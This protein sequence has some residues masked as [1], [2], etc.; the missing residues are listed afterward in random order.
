MKENAEQKADALGFAVERKAGRGG[1]YLLKNRDGEIVLGEGY[2]AGLKEINRFVDIHIKQKAAAV[3]VRLTTKKII[4]SF[5]ELSSGEARAVQRE[6]TTGY[7]L[8]RKE[9]VQDKGRA[10]EDR[11]EREK[12]ARRGG[13]DIVW[14]TVLGPD[15]SA[16][17]S[18]V[19]L[20]LNEGDFV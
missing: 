3:G 5:N 19:I 1:G 18:E 12:R 10:G 20:Y 16:T 11:E 13:E 9:V 7:K 17:L 6:A 4:D 8:E 15:H 2:T 14:V